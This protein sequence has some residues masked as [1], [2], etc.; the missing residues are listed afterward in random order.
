[1]LFYINITELGWT[2]YDGVKHVVV[3][4]AIKQGRNIT[5]EGLYAYP[6]ETSY[7][8]IRTAW[9]NEWGAVVSLY[10]PALVLPEL[11]RSDFVSRM[12]ISFREKSDE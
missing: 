4:V 2:M 1:M 6:Y 9:K 5:Q 11:P 10:Q 8:D 7:D 3:H 12:V